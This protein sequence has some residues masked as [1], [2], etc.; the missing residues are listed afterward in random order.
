MPCGTRGRILNGYKAVRGVAVQHR[1]AATLSDEQRLRTLAQ[2]F[3]RSEAG[4]LEG[5]VPGTPLCRDP[6]ARGLVEALQAAPELQNL[7]DSAKVDQEELAVIEGVR[8]AF[9]DRFVMD[10]LKQR[11]RQIVLIGS[12]MDCRVFRLELPPQMRFIEVD[13]EAV[14]EAKCAALDG[15]GARARCLVSRKAVPLNE[16]LTSAAL[17]DAI[18]PA[19]DSQKPTLFMLDGA[20]TSWPAEAR[21]AA[22]AAAAALA[23]QGSVIVGPAPGGDAAP[24]LQQSGF[25]TVNITNSI[26]LSKIFRRE[27]PQS[28]EMLVAIHGQ[29]QGARSGGGGGGCQGKSGGGGSGGP[30]SRAREIKF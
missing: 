2:A 30:P 20:L 17:V 24:L 18:A 26:Q 8:C 16:E 4:Q 21:S 25:G 23:A 19:I 22:L 7:L 11:M 13:E 6:Y 5:P 1:F 14:H 27:V 15:T 29:P 28:M 10:S 3:W 12:G 9:M